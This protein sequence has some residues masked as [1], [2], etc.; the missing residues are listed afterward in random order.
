LKLADADVE[1]ISTNAGDKG[2]RLNPE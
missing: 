1:F 2:N